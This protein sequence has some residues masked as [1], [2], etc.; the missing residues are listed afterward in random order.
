MPIEHH[1]IIEKTWL[2]EVLI[3]AVAFGIIIHIFGKVGDTVIVEGEEVILEKG[4]QAVTIVAQDVEQ[5]NLF[6]QQVR[7][8]FSQ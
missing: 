6:V 1:Q 2:D 3:L 4:Q 7:N 8:R 5:Y